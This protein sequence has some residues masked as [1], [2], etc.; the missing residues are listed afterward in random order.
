[1]AEGCGG[2]YHLSYTY[3]GKLNQQPP[4]LSYIYGLHNK[5]HLMSPCLDCFTTTNIYV[6]TTLA[7]SIV[8]T[9]LLGHTNKMIVGK[10]YYCNDV[11]VHT[12]LA[13]SIVAR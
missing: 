1:M 10:F 7:T 9:M 3:G 12:T 4:T 5:P 2:I 13:T 8:R 11:S 6:C